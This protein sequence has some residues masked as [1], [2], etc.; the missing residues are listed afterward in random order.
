MEG[1]SSFQP[2]CSERPFLLVLEQKLLTSLHERAAD[3]SRH[4][5]KPKGVHQGSA[6]SLRAAAGWE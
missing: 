4:L 6:L 3:I 1:H 2:V 5:P